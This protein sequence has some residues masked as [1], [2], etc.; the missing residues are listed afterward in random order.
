MEQ[1]RALHDHV[2]NHD[3]IKKDQDDDH[4]Y[5]SDLIISAPLL[6]RHVP[7]LQG[8]AGNQLRGESFTIITIQHYHYDKN[9]QLKLCL[10]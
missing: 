8:G 7:S 5:G 3:D 9:H 6:P 2:D 4:D 1:V 10:K